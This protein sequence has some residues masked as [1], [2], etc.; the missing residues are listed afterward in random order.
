M[1]PLIADKLERTNRF[2][3]RVNFEHVAQSTFRVNDSNLWDPTQSKGGGGGFNFPPGCS[4]SSAFDALMHYHDNCI[5]I[6]I[7]GELTLGNRLSRGPISKG[8]SN[9]EKLENT[10]L[11]VCHFLCLGSGHNRYFEAKPLDP[12]QGIDYRTLRS[13]E[14]VAYDVSDLTTE[15]QVL[16]SGFEGTLY[17]HPLAN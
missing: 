3:V 13:P 11:A 1:S 14:Q 5:M 6:W 12:R 9:R 8:L 7:D 15:G 10:I 16:G 4:S 17:I 2:Y